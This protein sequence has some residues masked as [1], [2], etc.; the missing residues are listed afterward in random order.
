MADKKTCKDCGE[1]LEEQPA[2]HDLAKCKETERLKGRETIKQLKQSIIGW[3]EAWYHQR[4]VIADLWWEH[5]IYDNEE[6]FA[7]YQKI[8]STF[9]SHQEKTQ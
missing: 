3:R 4:D 9:T 2:I 1:F 8:R 6:E 5:P 7:Y